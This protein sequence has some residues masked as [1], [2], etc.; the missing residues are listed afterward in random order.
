MEGSCEYI[1]YA[2][3]DSRWGTVSSVVVLGVSKQPL[4]VETFMFQ[5][6]K[7]ASKLDG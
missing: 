5:N 6:G 2:V 7:W 4:I 3:E 1:E